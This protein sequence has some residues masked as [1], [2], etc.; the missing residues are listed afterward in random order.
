MD[1]R[2]QVAANPRGQDE[3]DL[4]LRQRPGAAAAAST[5]SATETEASDPQ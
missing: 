2:G 5:N 4:E 1:S 3:A